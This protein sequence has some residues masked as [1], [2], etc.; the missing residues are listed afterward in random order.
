MAEQTDILALR[1]VLFVD[2]DPRFLEMMERVV[3]ALSGG[4]WETSVAANASAAL[5]FLQDHPVDLVIIDVQM[6]VVDGLQFLTIVHAAF[7]DQKGEAAF[8]ALLSIKGG[9]FRLLPF[10]DPPERSID[11]SW[12]FLLMKARRMR[13]EQAASD[14]TTSRGFETQIQVPGPDAPPEDT[15]KSAREDVTTMEKPAGESPPRRAMAGGG[16]DSLKASPM[17]PPNLHLRGGGV[18]RPSC[19]RRVQRKRNRQ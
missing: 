2:D 8:N 7:R 10:R 1:K 11:C 19:R 9:E 14:E 16:F 15:L 4:A 3:G 6:P 12:E 17:G 13:D 18:L 5:T